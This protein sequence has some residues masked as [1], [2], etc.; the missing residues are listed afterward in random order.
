MLL[1][2]LQAMTDITADRVWVGKSVGGKVTAFDA[3]EG[4]CSFDGG[5]QVTTGSC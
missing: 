2:Q 4:C 3:D 1:G 5:W